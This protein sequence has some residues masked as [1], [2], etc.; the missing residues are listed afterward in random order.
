MYQQAQKTYLKNEIEGATKGKLVLLLYDGAIKFINMAV[1][2]IEEKNIVAAHENIIKAENI[3]YELLSTL[4]MEAGEIAE[5]LFKLYDFA[6]WQ[7]VEANKTKDAEKLTPVL[8]I[9]KTLR[10]AWKEVVTQ[11]ELEKQ[12]V[13]NQ[14][15]VDNIKLN[16]AG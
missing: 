15:K 4:N 2:G 8:G 16:V 14:Q 13:N 3:L 1:K 6:I 12:T 10:D 5:N 11:E 7:L 9:L